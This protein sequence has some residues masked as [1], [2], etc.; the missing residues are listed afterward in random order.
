LGAQ[1]NDADMKPNAVPFLFLP[2]VALIGSIAGGWEG[3]AWAVVAWMA[4]VG[5]GT[6]VHLVRHASESFGAG[7]HG[8]DVPP[9]APARSKG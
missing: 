2:G 6:L 4:V 9:P 8:V 7:A 1:V 3:L 5:A